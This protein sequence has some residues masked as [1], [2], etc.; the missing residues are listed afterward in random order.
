MK[1]KISDVARKNINK[2]SG[3]I[4]NKIYD[5]IKGLSTG[6]TRYK[7]LQDSSIY[8]CRMGDYRILF[9]IDSKGNYTIR[10][11]RH[12]REVYRNI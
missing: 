6:K 2:L 4:K 8:S 10:T 11:V 9:D 5:K 3:D 7:R 12:R 1:I